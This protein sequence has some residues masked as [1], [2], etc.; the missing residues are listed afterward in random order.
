MPSKRVPAAS[1]KRDQHGVRGF[2]DG[3]DEDAAVGVE[4]IE[5]VADAQHAAL[6]V[7]VAREGLRGRWIRG[8]R[9]RRC[10]GRCRFM[11]HFVERHDREPSSD[12]K[13]GL[14]TYSIVS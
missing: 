5:V 11:H 4:I 1:C 12:L 9:D 13:S 6:A 10:G 14:F 8:A 3:D 2:A 7:Q